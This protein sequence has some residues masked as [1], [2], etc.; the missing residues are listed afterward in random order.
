MCRWKDCLKLLPL[1]RQL[2]E[3]CQSIAEQNHQRVSLVIAPKMQEDACLM[4]NESYLYRAFDNVIRN[5]MAYSPEGSTIQVSLGQ[6]AR[7]SADRY[8]RQRPGRG[9][10]AAAAY[11]HRV[12]P[13][14]Q[15]RPQTRHRLGAGL[16][17]T[18]CR[19]AR[20]AKSSPE[21]LQPNGLRMRISLPKTKPLKAW[22]RKRRKMPRPK[23][24][25]EPEQ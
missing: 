9:R 11:L 7:P 10:I 12:L 8:C 21:N 22:K 2:V 16:D 15:Q 23:K 4:A 13:R 25:T 5:A 24:E 17:Q 18:Y 6:D 1:L 20:A 14:R 3:D 19:P